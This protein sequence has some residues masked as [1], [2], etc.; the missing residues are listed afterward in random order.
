MGKLPIFMERGGGTKCGEG[1]GGYV[2]VREAK[3]GF[4]DSGRCH[5]YGV[6]NAASSSL[7]GVQR[8]SCQH[9]GRN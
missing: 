9:E 2:Q 1:Y 3:I 8:G 6:E 5:G 4:A 7:R